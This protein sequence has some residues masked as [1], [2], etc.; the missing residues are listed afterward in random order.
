M[1]NLTVIVPVYNEELFLE[2]SLDRLLALEK[3]FKILIVDDC[4]NDNSPNIAQQYA[5]EYEYITFIKKDNNGGKGSVLKEAFKH[6]NTDFSVI[7]DADLEYFPEDL[8]SMYEN[9]DN[10]SFVLGSRFIGNLERKNIYIRT[11]IANKIMSYFF[12][13]IFFTKV[14]DIATCYKMF[15]TNSLSNYEIKE[16]G[17]SIEIE[18]AAKLIK[19]KLNY[20]EVPIK[21]SGRS[22]EEGK[23]IK[24]YDGIFYLF[25][26]L[27]YRI[28]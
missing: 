6:V 18:L 16:K 10:K 14:T 8:L 1:K 15:P 26:T 3:D 19:S 28:K 17:F 27:K 11:F 24:F 2:Q 13:L 9:I 5:K 25:N 22:Y 12:S 7:H 23:K 21:Y 20:S 4:S